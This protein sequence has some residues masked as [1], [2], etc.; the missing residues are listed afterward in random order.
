MGLIVNVYTTRES[1]D[2]TRNGVTNRFNKLCVVN[3]DGPFEPDEK[4]P[5][6]ELVRGA[7]EGI[8]VLKPLEAKGQWTM[9]GG[10]YAG[11]SDSRFSN[12]VEKIIGHRFYGAVP[13][14]DR[15]ES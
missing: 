2:C 3:V 5:A 9:F 4:T 10:N 8:A 13:V 15:V 1:Y 11:C 6:V 14:H 7:V 12:A